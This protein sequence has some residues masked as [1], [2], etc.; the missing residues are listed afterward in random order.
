LKRWGDVVFENE[1]SRPK[2]RSFEK[3]PFLALKVKGDREAIKKFLKY[4]T[5]DFQVFLTSQVLPNESGFH[6]YALVCF[7][8][9]MLDLDEVFN[10]EDVKDE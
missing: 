9:E 5:K 8:N 10:E 6:V 4:L 3:T 2:I 1:N 7:K